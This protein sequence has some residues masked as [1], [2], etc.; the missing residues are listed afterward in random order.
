ME[1]AGAQRDEIDGANHD[2]RFQDVVRRSDSHLAQRIHTPAARIVRAAHHP[3]RVAIAT[4]DRQVATRDRRGHQHGLGD[5]R[6]T[7]SPTFVVPPADQPV[8]E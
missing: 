1:V 5:S 8:P 3:T 4:A 6:E 7:E 2:G